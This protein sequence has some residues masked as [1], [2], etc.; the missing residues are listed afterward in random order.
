MVCHGNRHGSEDGIWS[1]GYESIRSKSMIER[2]N[3]EKNEASHGK[4]VCEGK[5]LQTRRFS[6]LKRH[7]TDRAS[8]FERQ[9]YKNR[10][11]R[12]V[13]GVWACGTHSLPVKRSPRSWHRENW[14]TT[15]NEPNNYN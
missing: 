8:H 6:Q 11:G 12:T 5:R 13:V 2:N 7:G 3:R 9:R 14:F 10:P 4:P 1:F 15:L